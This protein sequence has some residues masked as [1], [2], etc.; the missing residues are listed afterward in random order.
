MYFEIIYIDIKYR[1]V[2]VPFVY[3]WIVLLSSFVRRRSSLVGNESRGD[4]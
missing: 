1:E 4:S 3:R 2:H